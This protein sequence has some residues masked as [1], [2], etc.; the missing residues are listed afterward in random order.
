MNCT[1]VNVVVLGDDGQGKSALAIQ[2]RLF[3][4]LLAC[5]SVGLVCHR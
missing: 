4:R 3:V 2:V 1:N 5:C